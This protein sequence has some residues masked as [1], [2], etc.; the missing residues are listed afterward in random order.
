MTEELTQT[1]N[2]IQ[3]ALEALRISVLGKNGEITT[4]LKSLGELPQEERREAG[5]AANQHRL[6]TNGRFIHKSRFRFIGRPHV[7]TVY[8]NFDALNSPHNHPSRDETDTFYFND[9]LL[10]RT[11]TSPMQVHAMESQNPR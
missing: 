6:C 9:S 10:L 5:Q 2:Q 1:R 7:E 8:H 11:H 4:L 3:S